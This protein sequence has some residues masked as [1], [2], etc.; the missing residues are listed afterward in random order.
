MS[1][2]LHLLVARRLERISRAADQLAVGD[3]SARSGV[4]GRDEIAQLG[5]SFDAMV[6]DMKQHEA[7]LIESEER[8]RSLFEHAV[9]G[10]ITMGEDRLIQSI[11]PAAQKMFGYTEDEV[12]GK[13]VRILMPSPYHEEHDGYVKNYMKTGKKKIIGIG[14]E[15]VG[16]R[17]DG[18]SF[19]IELSVVDLKLKN[20]RIFTGI[21]RDITGR[22][23]AEEALQS[24]N[25]H[26]EELVEKRTRALAE[27]QETLVRTERLATLGQLAGSVAHEI[28]NPLGIVRNASYY[29]EQRTE[30]AD[31][32]LLESFEEIRRGLARSD[33]IITELLDYARD[34]QASHRD[35]VLSEAIMDSVK[36]I[37]IGPKHC[38]A[39]PERFPEVFGYGDP[40]QM[41]RILKNLIING[42]QAMPDGGKV[43]VACAING[44]GNAVIEVQDTGIGM[45]EGQLTKIFEPLFTTKTRGI[46]LG[47]AL[48]LRYAELNH[49]SLTAESVEGYGSTFRL[50]VPIRSE[51]S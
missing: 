20:Q 43:T 17:K 12:V 9:E 31:E 45:N 7:A 15:V 6:N 42:L 26:L 2:L 46:G 36:G 18:T 50:T 1:L 19:P 33:R 40:D 38:V 49:G 3:L 27:V 41:S 24:L 28:R 51:I 23:R 35:F 11:N 37:E 22:K 14:R 16:E 30:N 29:V 25:E 44:D 48:S 32:E 4:R 10:I 21:V 47:L 5:S 39:L 13:N 8:H 34:P